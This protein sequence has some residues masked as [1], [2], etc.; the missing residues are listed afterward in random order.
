MTR[1][2]VG[3]DRSQRALCTLANL[4]RDGGLMSYRTN[5]D[6]HYPRAADYVGKILRGASP[7]EL[8]VE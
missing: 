7:R 5:L 8:P 1:F 4:V 2:V 3:D 6:V